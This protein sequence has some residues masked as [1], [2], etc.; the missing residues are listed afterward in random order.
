MKR[1]NRKSSVILAVISI[2]IASLITK[3]PKWDGSIFKGEI[4]VSG[5]DKTVRL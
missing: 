2:L 5:I 1:I 4:M 3:E